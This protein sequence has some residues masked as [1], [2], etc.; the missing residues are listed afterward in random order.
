MAAP[1]KACATTVA[2]A[3]LAA[4]VG[5]GCGG[6]YAIAPVMHADP[7]L[8][9]ADNH[10]DLARE[11]LSS[12]ELD[13]AEE[14][15]LMALAIYEVLDDKRKIGST[16]RGL[17]TIYGRRDEFDG[18][19]EM[20]RK[21]L[22][23]YEE[24]DDKCL[25]ASTYHTLGTICWQR[26]DLGHAEEMY[27]KAIEAGAPIG[28]K[29][30]PGTYQLSLARVYEVRGKR[31]LAEKMYREVLAIGEKFSGHSGHEHAIMNGL[32]GIAKMCV[33]R[34][35]L[36][37]AEK[38]YRNMLDLGLKLQKGERYVAMACDGLGD[39]LGRKR[40]DLKGA[41]EIYR[42][43]LAAC[44]HLKDKRGMAY[45]YKNLGTVYEARGDENAAREHWTKARDLYTK[46]G[47]AED[48]KEMQEQI[49]DL[50]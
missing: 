37:G 16:Y 17:G 8:A 32:L 30:M 10:A 29:P 7:R 2:V 18:E 50:D 6:G 46:L 27:R 33:K 15:W 19:E 3:T 48:T 26:D 39:I 24:L 11:R 12:G 43:A 23:I 14:E 42:R 22:A 36:D 44:G 45:E 41:E 49:D 5:S 25:I 13:A 38:A 40:G 1:S 21:A 31:D 9:E 20:Y 4:V 28:H 35:D 47:M 34:G